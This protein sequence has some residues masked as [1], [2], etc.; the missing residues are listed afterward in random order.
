[1]NVGEL[2]RYMRIIGALVT[3]D[4]QNMPVFMG[5]PVMFSNYLYQKWE[6]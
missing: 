3:S 2:L 6:M 1:M 5:F 4:G